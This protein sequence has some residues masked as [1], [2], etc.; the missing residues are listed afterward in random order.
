MDHENYRYLKDHYEKEMAA[1]RSRIE[2][3]EYARLSRHGHPVTFEA[4]KEKG[5][6][7]IDALMKERTPALEKEI[8]KDFGGS[9]AEARKQ[10]EQHFQMEQQRKRDHERQK[11]IEAQKQKQQEQ[12]QRKQAEIRRQQQEATAKAEQALQDF[13]TQSINQDK[14]KQRESLRKQYQASLKRDNGRQL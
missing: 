10:V 13:N 8:F 2:E 3:Q 6:Q 12:E 1:M 9:Q 14:E 7:N 11:F 4:F 5:K